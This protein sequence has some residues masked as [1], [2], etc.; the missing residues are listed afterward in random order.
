M[1]MMVITSGIAAIGLLLNSPAVIFG[2]M[3]VSPLMVP[4]R[5]CL[6]LRTL[7]ATSS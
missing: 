5:I 3:L 6:A 1:F 4:M 2:A 7:A